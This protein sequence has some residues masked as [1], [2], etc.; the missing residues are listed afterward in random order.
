[1]SHFPRL[2][3]EQ[4]LWFVADSIQEEEAREIRE[5]L[6][7]DGYAGALVM[8]QLILALYPEV[9]I[10]AQRDRD[11]EDWSRSVL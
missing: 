6:E 11:F 4:T 2:T 1:M 5:H 3:P 9:V 8:Q 7:H 10:P